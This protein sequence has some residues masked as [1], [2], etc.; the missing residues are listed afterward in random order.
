[1]E[2]LKMMTTIELMKIINNTALDFADRIKAQTEIL[3]REKEWK[4]NIMNF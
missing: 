2:P 4:S 1:M 3:R